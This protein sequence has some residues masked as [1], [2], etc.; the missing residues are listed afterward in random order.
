MFGISESFCN[1]AF[2]F[3]SLKFQIPVDNKTCLT[4]SYLKFVED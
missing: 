3:E 4:N 2:N 1:V